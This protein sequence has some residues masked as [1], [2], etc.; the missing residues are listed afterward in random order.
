MVERMFDKS[1]DDSCVWV[2]E[3]LEHIPP[4]YV[5]AAMLDD[6]DIELCSGFDRIRLVQAHE[7]MQAHYAARSY[8]AMAAVVDALRGDEQGEGLFDEAAEA[9]AVEVAA[10]LRLTRRAADSKMAMALELNRRLPRVWAML[11]DGV[12]DVRRAEV[13]V[14]GTLHLSVAA[15]RGVVDEVIDDAWLLTTGQLKV[16]L[17]KLCID[18]DPDDAKDRYRHAVKDRK[19]VVEANDTGTGNLHAL[20]L[21]PHRVAAAREHINRLALGLKRNGDARTMDQLRADVLLDLWMAP[22]PWN[23][24]VRAQLG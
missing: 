20:D 6:I 10:A 14:D 9:G 12:I 8:H 23:T 15:A 2:P 1:I 21:P 3:H 18:V 4:G 5:L 19:V 11:C 17:R 13:L 7:R 24:T 22:Q 16:K